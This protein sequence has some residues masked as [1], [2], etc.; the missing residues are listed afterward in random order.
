MGVH[1]VKQAMRAGAIAAALVSAT[2]AQAAVTVF[3]GTLTGPAESPPNSSPGIGT[4]LVSIDP[5][6]HQ[7]TLTV[8]FSGL[9]PTTAAGAPSG[10][11]A[12]HIHAP[13]PLPLTGTASVATQLPSFVGF[14]TGVTAGSY[15]NTFNTLDPL[16]YNPAFITANGNT[17]AGAEAALFGAIGSGRAYLNIH[18]NAFPQGEIRAFLVAVPEPATWAMMLIGFGAMGW[19]IRRRRT[20]LAAA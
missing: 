9:V 17:V 15:T 2:T 3:G 13:T 1:F 12:A 19:S 16:F 11:T 20:S 8:S 5:V 10:T 7:L 6:T 18:S 14:P 4:T